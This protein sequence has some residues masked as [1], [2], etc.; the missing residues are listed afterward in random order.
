MP[1]SLNNAYLL[2][3]V[4]QLLQD[5]VTGNAGSH[6]RRV[7]FCCPGNGVG[8]SPNKKP[9]GMRGLLY[10]QLVFVL[11]NVP[12]SIPRREQKSCSG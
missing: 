11:V 1:V 10:S 8:V 4:A 5:A 6:D 2:Y 12:Y 7:N 9:R 3:T